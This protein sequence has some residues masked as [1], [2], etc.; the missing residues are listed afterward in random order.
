MARST[1]LRTCFSVGFVTLLLIFVS[2]VVLNLRS[3]LRIDETIFDDDI[4]AT[5]MELH[6]GYKTVAYFVNW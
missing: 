6:F 2:S 4:L 1:T 5:D 3:G